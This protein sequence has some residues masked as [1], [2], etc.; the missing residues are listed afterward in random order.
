MGKLEIVYDESAKPFG[1]GYRFEDWI[2]LDP[3]L[4]GIEQQ[5][6]IE[7]LQVGHGG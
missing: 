1:G 2:V 4:S 3:G 6:R 5:I 7:T